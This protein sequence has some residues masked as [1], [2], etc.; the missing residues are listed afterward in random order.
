MKPI[1]DPQNEHDACGVGMVA[2]LDNQPSHQTVNDALVILEKLEHRG[3]TGADPDSGD[4]AGILLQV[5]DT[6][7]REV[8]SVEGVDLPSAGNY[9]V[10]Q[11]ML[12]AARASSQRQ[13]IETAC[14]QFG[15]SLIAWREIP[16]D[17][18]LLGAAS[19]AT[20]PLHQ[21]CVVVPNEPLSSDEFEFRLYLARR[22]ASIETEAYASSFSSRTVI[23][24][25]MLTSSQLRKYFSDLRDPRIAS[26]V[27]LVHSRFSTNTFPQWNLAQP[28]RY[29]A[30]NGEINTVRSNRSWLSA[31]ES[32]MSSEKW[33]RKEDY[34]P[35]I[36]PHMSDSASFDEV[37]ELL[38]MHGRSL[39]HSI[40]MM[41]PEAWERA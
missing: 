38:Y 13:G 7:L 8:F 5:P 25:G 20:E 2:N 27:A 37:A 31:R 29:I 33:S 21:M 36:T 23:Y 15:L 18:S 16:V 32:K 10:G 3:A 4:G 9:G 26:A 19:R 30:H 40:L 1:Y 14:K 39:P 11:W 12:D 34:T 28:F 6:F 17:S 35:V 41:I 24:K 22:A